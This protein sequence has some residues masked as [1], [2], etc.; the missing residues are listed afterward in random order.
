MTRSVGFGFGAMLWLACVGLSTMGLS[1]MSPSSASAQDAVLA[2]LYGQGVHE[3]NSGNYA[4]AH[5]R[6]T[7]AVNAGSP[8]PRVFYFRGL[9]YL[10]LGRQDEASA[11]FKRASELEVADVNRVYPV[12][13]ALERVQGSTRMGMEAYRMQ[14]RVAAYQHETD[15]RVKRFGENRGAAAS[16]GESIAPPPA[17]DLLKGVKPA[18]EPA[19]PKPAP[20]GGD[21][22]FGGEKPG[23]PAAPAA[24][25]DKAPE[26]APAP[27]AA[28]V[29]PKPA[30]ADPFGGAA[31]GGAAPAAP[32]EKKDDLKK[33][34]ADPFGGAP[35]GGGA[36]AGG[37]TPAVVVPAVVA[38]AA[39]G[40]AKAADPFGGA[41]PA[42]PA[43]GAE[44]P[45]G[46]EPAKPAVVV[47][48]KGAADPFAP[49][50]AA[51]PG[52]APGG[53]P[54]APPAAPPV[55][56]PAAAPV[57]PPAAPLPAPADPAKAPVPAAAN[58]FGGDVK[59]AEMKRVDMAPPAAPAAE[60]AQDA[61]PA[62]APAE[63]KA[64]GKSD[65]N[66]FG[67]EAPKK[68]DA[69]KATEKKAEEKKADD[70]KK[71]AKPAEDD[72]FGSK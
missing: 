42:A 64:G 4:Q 35:A 68:A 65:D 11:D 55:A 5:E 67:D 46:M 49:G 9:S 29:A 31:P 66:P 63:K 57:A 17:D 39:G 71:P 43:D 36:A 69:A 1:I 61:A 15:L 3:Y 21:D 25:A 44:A 48:D 2:Q 18:G 10:Q 56:P 50:A 27:P 58:P 52:V 8:D 16:Q 59:P 30:D 37:A 60:P 34:D 22:L 6:L 12:D 32:A 26:A 20:K 54:A 38:P 28:P 41:A 53:A 40:A 13:K 7:A 24:P 19:V 14:A 45:K 23:A 70:A 47:P 33:G 72:P 62:A 51:P